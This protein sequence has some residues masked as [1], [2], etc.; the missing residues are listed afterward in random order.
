MTLCFDTVWHASDLLGCRMCWWTPTGALP[1]ECSER[2]ASSMLSHCQQ[3]FH[4]VSGATL[5]KSFSSW[6]QKKERKNIES[7]LTVGLQIVEGPLLWA[8]LGE[9]FGE[10]AQILRP[11]PVSSSLSESLI[12]DCQFGR[13]S[14]FLAHHT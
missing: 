2:N 14:C 11:A 10:L 8:C 4:A 5:F 3:T 1:I 6:S 7:S 9:R 12:R 13:C